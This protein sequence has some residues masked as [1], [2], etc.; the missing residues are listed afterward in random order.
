VLTG[1]HPIFQRKINKKGKPV[2]KPV[3]T[4]FTFDFSNP[5]D[6]S[7]AA[8]PANYQVDAIARKKAKKTVEPILQ[9]IA[10]FSVTYAAASDAVTITFEGKETFPTG[11]QITVLGGVT[12]ASGGPS[13]GNLVFT[14]SRGGMTISI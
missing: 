13:G 1:Q 11:G 14:I 3:L 10:T 12:T 9:P 2:G 6:P 4:G 7:A 8:N 5:L